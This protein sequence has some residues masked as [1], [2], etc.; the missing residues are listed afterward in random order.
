[1]ESD[2]QKSDTLWADPEIS[3]LVRIGTFRVTQEVTVQRMEYLTEFASIYPIPEI[4]TAI[5]IDAQNEKF[6]FTDKKGRLR[7]VDAI[8]KN[9]VRLQQLIWSG[10]FSNVVPRITTPGPVERGL[11]IR[12]STL[13]L[14]PGCRQFCAADRASNAQVPCA[15]L[16]NFRCTK[17]VL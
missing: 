4:P 9:K 15:R 7:S 11:Q 13:R 2:L 8:I 14:S 12:K 1:M 5:V 3:S 10:F 6:N 17:H 16:S